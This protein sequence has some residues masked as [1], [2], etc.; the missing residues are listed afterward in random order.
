MSDQVNVNV[1]APA[2]G[3]SS[4]TTV[5]ALLFAV[6]VVAMLVWV[7]AF[8]GLNSVASGPAPAPAKNGTTIN[9]APNV[10]V[11]APSA[12]APAAP[13]APVKP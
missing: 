1:P 10:N 13:A 4:A 8:G 7:L 11:Q 3:G 9:I 5:V 6:V 2:G 12:P